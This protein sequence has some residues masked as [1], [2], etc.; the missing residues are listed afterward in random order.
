MTIAPETK[1]GVVSIAV[2][3]LERALAF[4]EN[5][6]G[7]RQHRRQGQR[8][9][10]G[11]GG[12]DLLILNEVPGAQQT[13]GT[14]GLYHFAILLPTRHDLARFLRHFADNDLRLQ[15]FSDHLVSEAIYLSDPDGNGIEVYRDRPRSQWPRQD[16]RLQMATDP[17]DLQDLL[18]ELTGEEPPWAKL[19]Q[20]TTIGHI[21]LHVSNLSRDERFYHEVLGF[22]VMTRYGAS[23]SFL[24]AGGYHHHVGINVWAGVGAAPAPENAAGLR[25]YT[26]DLPSREALDALLERLEETGVATEER[27]E[28]LFLRDRSENG[29]VLRV[30]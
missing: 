14:T 16:G 2:S 4:Y 29:I 13:K 25:W 11:A 5:A 3:D 18:A 19:P 6:L 28:G 27:E 21:H 24:S 23:A 7:F 20:E 26:I 12:P 22:D 10:L 9:F 15:G 17:L 8:A 1:I 30:A